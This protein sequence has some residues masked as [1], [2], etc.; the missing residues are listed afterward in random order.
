ME[1]SQKKK[2]NK[3]KQNK[4]PQSSLRSVHVMYEEGELWG[5]TGEGRRAGSSWLCTWQDSGEIAL[6]LGSSLPDI[7]QVRAASHHRKLEGKQA[8]HWGSGSKNGKFAGSLKPEVKRVG[9][10]AQ[11]LRL[12]VSKLDKTSSQNKMHPHKSKLQGLM[13]Q[14]E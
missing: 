1:L 9:G 10:I 5:Q 2:A 13:T 14:S 4:K 12:F 11:W 6:A 7:C 3:T 8:W